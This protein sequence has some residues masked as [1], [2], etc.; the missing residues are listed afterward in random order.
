MSFNTKRT[1]QGEV[2]ELELELPTGEVQVY[3]VYCKVVFVT[4]EPPAG[5]A[6]PPDKRTYRWPYF[7]LDMFSNSAD[8]LGMR[9]A[10]DEEMAEKLEEIA[11]EEEERFARMN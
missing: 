1:D 7:Y 11:R 6:S 8:Q 4:L 9:P 2:W 10:S 5:F 3:K